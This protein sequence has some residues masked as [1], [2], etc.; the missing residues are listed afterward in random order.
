MNQFI[1]KLVHLGLHA[2]GHA[3]QHHRKEKR[4]V[5]EMA[6]RD[7]YGV[8]D[9][10]GAIYDSCLASGYPL[11]DIDDDLVIYQFHDRGMCVG[12][13]DTGLACFAFTPFKFYIH[14]P[15]E[16]AEFLEHRNESLEYGAWALP[17]IEDHWTVAYRLGINASDFDAELFQMATRQS[18]AERA[19]VE[20]IL[21]NAGFR[22]T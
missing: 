19:A 22:P 17:K 13:D 1:H 21:I 18:H 14:V 16:I 15:D 7:A 2:A 12:I 10:A 4:R 9:F 6:R 8:S 3:Y 11:I 5:A 20:D